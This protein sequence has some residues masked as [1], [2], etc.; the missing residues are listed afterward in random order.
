LE[1]ILAQ[2]CK[3]KFGLCSHSKIEFNRDVFK[4]D[5]GR[6][7][8]IYEAASP[9]SLE[10]SFLLSLMTAVKPLWLENWGMAA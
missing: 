7:V 2:D 5:R 10:R 1:L 4:K 3:R 9:R 6:P 8:F